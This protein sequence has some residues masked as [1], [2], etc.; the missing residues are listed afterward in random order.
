MLHLSW[1]N[2]IKTKLI[3]LNYGIRFEQGIQ[4]GKAE[5]VC[6][7]CGQPVKLICRTKG[8][9]LFFQHV[10][11][12][13]KCDKKN[14]R[15]R[16]SEGQIRANKYRGAKESREHK[17]MKIMIAEYAKKSRDVHDVR[18]ECVHKRHR[19]NLRRWRKAD[20]LVIY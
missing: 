9:K 18:I 12:S 6:F 11:S 16:P 19:N 20:V 17:E 2:I 8:K 14:D 1:R 10:R 15:E 4:A 3:Y 5:C 13:N 7:Y